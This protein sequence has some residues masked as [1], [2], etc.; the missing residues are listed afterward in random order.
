VTVGPY[1]PNPG[2]NGSPFSY[3]Q[4][5]PFSYDT[6]QTQAG[7]DLYAMGQ[8]QVAS[9]PPPAPEKKAGHGWTNPLT[10]PFEDIGQIWHDVETH[11]IAPVFTADHSVYSKFISRPI[12]T[13]LTYSA[14]Q[15]KKTIEGRE[16]F[17]SLV[18]FNS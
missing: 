14:E 2:N 10:N 16:N 8:Q 12:A 18:G 6:T 9:A 3:D 1:Q 4:G 13:V 11:T 17:G 7:A 15:S 5:S